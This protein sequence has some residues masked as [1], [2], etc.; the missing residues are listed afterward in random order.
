MFLGTWSSHGLGS[1]AR[2]G[3]A[4]FLGWAIVRE[5]APRRW[6]AA[7]L[8]PVAVVAF[9]IPGETDLLA[10]WCVLM[11]VRIASRSVGE[12]PTTLDLVLLAPFAAWVAT[13]PAGLPAALVLAAIV[14]LEEPR[15]RA[16]LAGVV[17]LLL[18]IASG[19]TEGTITMRP[20]WNDPVLLERVLLAAALAAAAVVLFTR[21]PARTRVRDDRKR[22]L[23]S[24]HRVRSARV[25]ALAS[26]LA[27]V[28]WSGVDGAFA[29]SSVSGA[30]LATGVGGARLQ[31]AR[32]RDRR[33]ERRVTVSGRV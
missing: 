31:A 21:A 18:V 33:H 16:R 11:A 2:G 30:V 28:A 24:G 15:R 20:S 19:A 26:V 27:A 23:I 13:R 22:G 29:L 5:L 9:A 1:G 7:A 14:F 10:C 17:A 12:P 32:R 8:A 3:M 6:L 25:A 4:V